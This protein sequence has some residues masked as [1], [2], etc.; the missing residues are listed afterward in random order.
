MPRARIVNGKQIDVAVTRALRAGWKLALLCLSVGT[1]WGQ[2][3]E[4]APVRPETRGYNCLFMGHSFFAPIA[5]ALRP[6]PAL[7]G[8]PEHR[9]TVVSHGGAN[10]SPG[11]LWNSPAE[12]VNNARRLL[13]SGTVDVLGLTF[14]PN[15]GS[16]IADY[17][18]WIDRALSSNP[19]TLVAIQAPWPMYRGKNLAVYEE[20]AERSV[21]VIRGIIA[22]LQTFYPET[23]FLCLP[24][25]R[26]MAGLWRLYEQGKLP[27]VRT[28]LGNHQDG[29]AGC[30][31]TDDLGHGGTVPVTHG[32]LLWLAILYRVDVRTFRGPVA[33]PGEIAELAQALAEDQAGCLQSRNSLMDAG[34][35]KVELDLESLDADGLRGPPAG[36]VAVSY[37]FAIPNT[38]PCL[39]EVKRIDATVRCMPGSRG[40]VGATEMQCLCVGSTH[41]DHFREVL[42]ALAALPYVER[43]IECHF[44]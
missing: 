31:F 32:A 34:G 35:Q 43:I 19:R 33:I 13:D 10:G 7:A 26:W 2:A 1:G 27:A 22:A 29:K 37:E 12:D 38:A 11:N 30:L 5:H 6:L 20:E 8:F 23:T 44:E 18:R 4:T 40:R 21:A 14:Y 36:K 9:Q 42:R 28:V 24:Q 17:R 25:A 16:E 41:Q 15:A 3:V 39:A